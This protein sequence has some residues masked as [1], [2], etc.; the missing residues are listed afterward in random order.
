MHFR[1]HRI[2]NLVKEGLIKSFDWL[3]TNGNLL[4]PF[5]VSLSNHRQIGFNQRFTK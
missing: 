3:R 5:V 2:D 1:I 4:N